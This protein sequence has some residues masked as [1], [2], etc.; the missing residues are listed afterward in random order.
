MTV[1]GMSRSTRPDVSGFII[2]NEDNDEENDA[3]V[4]SKK[5]KRKFQ[6]FAVCFK[7]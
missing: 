4:E 3:D 6:T 2:E 7:L 1:C 5:K